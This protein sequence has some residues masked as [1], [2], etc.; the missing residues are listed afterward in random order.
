MKK[1]ER[2][3][4][5]SGSTVSSP[6]VAPL[7]RSGGA[8]PRRPPSCVSELPRDPPGSAVS[9]S[10]GGGSPDSSESN[11]CS[12]SSSSSSSS[13]DDPDIPS[14]GPR[15]RFFPGLVTCPFISTLSS[16]SS[17]LLLS[18]KEV[19]STP[20]T[21]KLSAPARAG[22]VP[23]R[24]LEREL[25]RPSRLPKLLEVE[26]AGAPAEAW[27]PECAEDCLEV[28]ECDV[29]CKE[30][31]LTVA[32]AAR[33]DAGGGPRASAMPDVSTR[34]SPVRV[35]RE[36]VWAGPGLRDGRLEAAEGLP[37]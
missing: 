28:F 34:L 10:S 27:L 5:S 15:R 1:V 33:E 2:T 29:E 30:P 17:N 36:S 32:D 35:S 21:S 11:S 12:S 22:A 26:R 37:T 9:S 31:C 7:A 3:W 19:R 24:V 16:S 23:W 8:K 6:P 14:L 18:S 13:S 4:V 20:V 25:G